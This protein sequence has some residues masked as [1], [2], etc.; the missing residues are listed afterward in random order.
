MISF[1]S[2]NCEMKTFSFVS[3]KV[4]IAENASDYT[5]GCVV[6]TEMHKVAPCWSPRCDGKSSE[7]PQPETAVSECPKTGDETGFLQRQHRFARL[8]RLLARP[9]TTTATL[10]VRPDNSGDTRK[11][12]Q[13]WKQTR[14]G[15]FMS[16]QS[17]QK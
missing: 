17:R 4:H 12:S 14:L 13:G 10:R 16:M 9:S 15:R 3:P 6:S 5:V 2:G 1:M 7:S 8:M 11:N